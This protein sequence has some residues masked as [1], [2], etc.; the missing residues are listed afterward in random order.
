MRANAVGSADIDAGL[1]PFDWYLALVVDGSEEHGLP[2]AYR[3]R[4]QATA[5]CTDPD[6]VRREANLALL[7]GRQRMQAADSID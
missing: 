6:A 4:L 3:S 1:Q 7:R 5:S 2:M